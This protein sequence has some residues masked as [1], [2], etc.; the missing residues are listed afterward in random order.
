MS[1][2]N[3]SSVSVC[4]HHSAVRRIARSGT[5]N[6]ARYVT[7]SAKISSAIKPDSHE[8]LAQPLGPHH[9]PPHKQPENPHR[10]G[11]RKHGRKVEVESAQRA[12]SDRES[13]RPKTTA[14]WFSVTSAKAQNAQ[15]TNACAS[16]ASGRS[17][18]TLAWHSTSQTKSHTRLPMG[19]RWKSASFFDCRIL[20]R[21]GPKRRQ[22]P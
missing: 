19:K 13:Q 11:Q 5:K 15:K 7:I 20:S 10:A 22:N 9:K 16:P 8:S 4:A 21:M 18:M 17:R 12:P 14:Q 2:R 1:G 6:A 3:A